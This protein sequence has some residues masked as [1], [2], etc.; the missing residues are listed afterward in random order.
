LA[1]AFTQIGTDFEAANPGIHVVFNFGSSTDL[2][3]QIGSE[4]TADVFASASGT[5]MDTVAATPGV[6][7]RTD[8]A[9]NHLVVI[10]PTDNP[11]NIASLADLGNDGVQVVLGATGVPVGDYAREMLANANLADQVMP[12][13]VSNEPDDASVVSKVQSGEADAGIVYTSDLTNADVTPVD[14]PAN[15]DVIATYPIAVV[16]GSAQPDTASAF[17]DYITGVQGQATLQTFG[18]SPPPAGA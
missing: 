18:F 3:T 10:V 12:N 15:V 8:F 2:A 17:I 11:A 1:E 14:V 7:D 4:G 5:A 6:R 9:T 16:S 13:V